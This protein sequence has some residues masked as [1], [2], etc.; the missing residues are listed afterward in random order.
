[1]A[2]LFETG[3]QSPKEIRHLPSCSERHLRSRIDFQL[4]SEELTVQNLLHHVFT[5]HRSYWTNEALCIF[6]L[7]QIL[8]EAPTFH[9]TSHL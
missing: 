3:H 5:S 6:L 9:P 2:K 7:S 1:M 8:S 4:E